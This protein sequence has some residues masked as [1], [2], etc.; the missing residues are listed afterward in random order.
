VRGNGAFQSPKL[1][2]AGR[3]VVSATLLLLLAR[4]I[5]PADVGDRLAALDARWVALGLVVSVLQVLLLAWR[6]RHTA[7]RLGVALPFGDALREYYFGILLNQILPGGVAGD[8]S[9]AWRHARTEAP[10]GAAVRAVILE[11]L[12]GQVVMTATAV[13]CVVGLAAVGLFD[14]VVEAV[15]ATLATLALGAWTLGRVVRHSSRRFAPDSRVGRFW[16]DARRAF[17][18]RSAAPLQWGSAVAVV[19][20]Y[21]AVY[22]IAARAVGIETPTTRLAPLVA[23]VLMTMLIPVTVAGWGIRESA[24][25]LL[26]GAVGLTAEDGVAISVAYGLLVLVAALPGVATVIGPRAAGS[27]GRG[28]RDGRRR[29]GNGEPWV[30]A[31]RPTNRSPEG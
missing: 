28:R 31:R 27:A 23:P 12:G 14:A 11:R 5:D 2:A 10:T 3:L 9:R 4:V 13:A 25:A 17:W 8:V 6:W 26:W 15:A 20:T 19:A 18:E 16:A 24:A 29:A 22:L 21:V 30:E 1:R 7:G